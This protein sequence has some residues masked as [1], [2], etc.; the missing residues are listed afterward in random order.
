MPVPIVT[1][2]GRLG[3]DPQLRTSAS[4]N[5]WVS[6][7]ILSSSGRLNRQTHQWEDNASSAIS[8]IAFGDMAEHIASS[9][10][11]GMQ[12]IAQCRIQQGR[13][14]PNQPDSRGSLTYYV[15][16]IGPGLSNQTAQVTKAPSTNGFVGNQSNGGYQGGAGFNNAASSAAPQVA[17]D[18]FSS[19]S[20]AADPWSSDTSASNDDFGSFGGTT[21]FGSSSDDPEF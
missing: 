17:S 9:L 12:V 1:V 8:A 19:S 15:V 7:F 10:S 5:S 13:P 4:G 11:K 16:E 18:P 14:N 6:L 2:V 20:Q 3:T 21:E